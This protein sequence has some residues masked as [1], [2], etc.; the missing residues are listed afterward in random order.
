MGYGLYHGAQVSPSLWGGY[1]THLYLHPRTM[2]HRLPDGIPTDLMTLF[3]PLS[4]A[5]RWV[6]EV[7][8][9]GLGSTVVIEGPGQR[10]LLAVFA[11][12]RAGASRIIVTGTRRDHRA[13]SAAPPIIIAAK[14]ANIGMRIWSFISMS[15]SKANSSSAS[16]S[17][18]PSRPRA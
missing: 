6:Y 4:N 13:S 14:A 1:A 8:K 11:A 5:V 15:V 12:R 2:V 18:N 16:P 7:G 10:G 17:A 3:K 9:V